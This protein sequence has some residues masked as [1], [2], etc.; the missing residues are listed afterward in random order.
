[1]SST[2]SRAAY[3]SVDGAPNSAQ[4]VPYILSY[5][6]WLARRAD[7]RSD[8]TKNITYLSCV[9]GPVTPLLQTHIYTVYTARPDCKPH[10]RCS[11]ASLE[12]TLWKITWNALYPPA[13]FSNP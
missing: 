1:M 2:R 4:S 11:N 6:V 9:G 5:A 7:I 12:F 8:E 10:Q 13:T 3:S